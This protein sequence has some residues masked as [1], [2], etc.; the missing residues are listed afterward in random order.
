MNTQE[1]IQDYKQRGRSCV[2]YDFQKLV[3]VFA[4]NAILLNNAPTWIQN[5]SETE[6]TARDYRKGLFL[7]DYLLS[8]GGER[9]HAVI[10]RGDDGIVDIFADR[11]RDSRIVVIGESAYERLK[12]RG[13]VRL[14]TYEG[15]Y[16]FPLQ[17]INPDRGVAVISEDKGQ[18][19]TKLD[20]NSVMADVRMGHFNE[21]W[22]SFCGVLVT[23]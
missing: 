19:V 21:L 2:D 13:N 17:V 5:N 15:A 10:T 6:I 9:K 16:P 1:A 12:Q 11:L 7:V 23:K 20:L 14:S 8:L 22:N 3:E 4:R 18:L